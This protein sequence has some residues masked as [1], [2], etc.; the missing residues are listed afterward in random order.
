MW[1][2]DGIDSATHTS[3]REMRGEGRLAIKRP[4]NVFNS[5]WLQQRNQLRV[6]I[7]KPNYIQYYQRVGHSSYAH[8]FDIIILLVCIVYGTG[9][10]GENA[11]LIVLLRVITI[12]PFG[13][14]QLAIHA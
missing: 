11:W 4:L 2:G 13:Q 9:K 6:N 14:M 8:V 5:K 3:E 7:A 1:A 12:G 10:N